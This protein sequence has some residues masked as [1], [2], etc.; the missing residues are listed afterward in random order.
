[1]PRVFSATLLDH[2]ES[3]KWVNP[4][5]KSIV[6]FSLYLSPR[7]FLLFSLWY[8]LLNIVGG[9][10]RLRKDVHQISIWIT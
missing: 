8:V 4:V 6:T 3:Q 2:R 5:R 10:H 7:L 9:V 1:M